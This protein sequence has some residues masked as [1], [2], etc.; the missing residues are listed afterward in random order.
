MARSVTP[1]Y[2]ETRGIPIIEGGEITA[3]DH[4]ARDGSIIIS[5]SVKE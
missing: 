2:F 4:T 5:V 3:D 1:G